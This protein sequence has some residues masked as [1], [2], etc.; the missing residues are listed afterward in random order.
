M[1]ATVVFG[2][3]GIGFI[4]GLS[5]EIIKNCELFIGAYDEQTD[6]SCGVLAA[7]II[8]DMLAIRHILVADNCRRMGAGR[9]MLEKLFEI[10]KSTDVSAI[11]CAHP[12]DATDGVK[13]FLLNAGFYE[14]ESAEGDDMKLYAYVLKV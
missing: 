7:E 13:E 4:N 8:D 9:A 14:D 11:I 5:H 1:K 3:N 2:S 12:A 6:T 10:A